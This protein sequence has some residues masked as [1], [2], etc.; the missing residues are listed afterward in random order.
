MNGLG[1]LQSA[2]IGDMHE[3]TETGIDSGLVFRTTAAFCGTCQWSQA[4]TNEIVPKGL[5]ERVELVDLV[6]SDR[7]NVRVRSSEDLARVEKELGQHAGIVAADPEYRFQSVG[8]GDRRLPFY[9]FVDSRTMV[10]RRFLPDPEPETLESAIRR[11][12]AQLDGTPPPPLA[13][14]AV[15]DGLFPRNH[16]EILKEMTLPGAPPKDPTNAVGD[17]PLAAALGKALFSDAR[18]SPSGNVSCATCHDPAKGYADGRPHGLGVADAQ[19]LGQHLLE[20]VINHGEEG[21]QDGTG[22]LAGA[23]SRVGTPPRRTTR[24]NS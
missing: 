24:H 16:W 22:K 19:V 8:L 7:N 14:P 18:L 15:E 9:V 11:E 17:S 3:L 4:H 6:V 2:I 12:V 23:A 20:L 5:E 13:D 1:R 21:P 10:I